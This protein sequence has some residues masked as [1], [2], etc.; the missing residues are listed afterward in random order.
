MSIKDG[1]I[2]RDGIES[3]KKMLNRG[4]DVSVKFAGSK[5]KEVATDLMSMQESVLAIASGVY[6]GDARTA[7]E[8]MFVIE[9]TAKGLKRNAPPAEKWVAK[10]TDN[11]VKLAKKMVEDPAFHTQYAQE[12]TDAI[13]EPLPPGKD[14]LPKK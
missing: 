11:M 3:L 13:M 4:V 9:L 7:A 10:D 6:D 8:A 5:A 2:A 14:M 1:V 12:V